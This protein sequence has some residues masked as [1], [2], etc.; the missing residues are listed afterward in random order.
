M[1]RRQAGFSL[2]EVAIVLL[3]IGLLLGGVLKGQEMV[4]QAKIKNLANDI[5]GIASAVYAYQ[6]RYR[7]LP[8]DDDRAE[9]RWSSPATKKGDASG[10]VGVGGITSILDC[11]L[12]ANADG[13]NCRFWQHLRLAGLVTG[14]AASAVPPQNAAGGTLQ[15]QSG[16]LG[17]S[18]LVICATGL[19]G[20][21]AEALDAQLDDGKPGS[22]QMRGTDVATALATPLAATAAYA[23]DTTKTYVV[24]RAV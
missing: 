24:C 23:D 22:G 11:T 9:G 4:S 19:P 3:V 10:Q 21:L 15:A 20:K 7:M 6:D 12:A 1:E 8:G 5:N 14:D 16:G 18:G 17:L 2:V 13:E